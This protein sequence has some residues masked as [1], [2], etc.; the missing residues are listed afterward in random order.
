MRVRSVIGANDSRTG[1]IGRGTHGRRRAGDIGF[2]LPDSAFALW[3]S[4][5]RCAATGGGN[6]SALKAGPAEIGF[7]LPNSAFALWASADRSTQ[8]RRGGDRGPRV[9]GP[10]ETGFV[11]PKPPQLRGGGDRGPG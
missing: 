1:T 4:A 11:P 7:V 10:A 6:G 5:D 3:A 8:P 2:V 9:A